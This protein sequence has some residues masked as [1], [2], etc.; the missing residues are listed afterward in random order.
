M[1]T[2][3]TQ[4]KV[5][6]DPHFFHRSIMDFCPRPFDSVQ[7][8]TDKMLD[9]LVADMGEH[10]VLYFL[11]DLMFQIG[12]Y[13]DYI[14]ERLQDV[15]GELRWILGNHDDIRRMEDIASLFS[16]VGYADMQQFGGKEVFFSHRP[17]LMPEDDVKRLIS[18]HGH[19]H[20][21]VHNVVGRMDTGVD[22]LYGLRDHPDV[23]EVLGYEYSFKPIL[24]QQAIELANR[25]IKPPY[26]CR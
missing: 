5:Y 23:R 21:T 26:L 1:K 14:Y 7:D 4:Y 16:F 24:L 20:G 17:L 22:S 11:G 25:D 18:I 12:T 3:Y 8:M 2:K 9:I 15:K 19:N 6:S 10:D 13:K